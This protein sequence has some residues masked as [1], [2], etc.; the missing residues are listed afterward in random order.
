MLWC[1]LEMKNSPKNSFDHLVTPI[2]LIT[3][4]VQITQQQGKTNATTLIC[5][6]TP[7]WKSYLHPLWPRLLL[8]LMCKVARKP[9]LMSSQNTPPLKRLKLLR[10]T[11]A[12]TTSTTCTFSSTTVTAPDLL[13]IKLFKRI[14]G[15]FKN[16]QVETTCT[17]LTQIWVLLI[18]QRA[19]E[20]VEPT[21]KK[22]DKRLFH[23]STFC[24]P[25][26][27]VLVADHKYVTSV[28][29]CAHNRTHLN[30]HMMIQQLCGC[31][32]L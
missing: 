22:I 1:N 16:I 7:L 11:R 14:F 20:K 8:E 2:I 27:W 30:W 25:I 28:V 9:V 18:C 12:S 17:N 23:G 19:V 6:S 21:C 29:W 13:V 3:P 4:A 10:S 24:I 15:S 5:R 26:T 32:P 31:A